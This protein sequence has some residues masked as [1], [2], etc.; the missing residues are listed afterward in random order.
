MQVENEM[1]V[2]VI[3][4]Q[5]AKESGFLVQSVANVGEGGPG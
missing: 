1:G 3:F 5:Q 4:A 2:I